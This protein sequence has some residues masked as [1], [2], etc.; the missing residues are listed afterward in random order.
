MSKLAQRGKQVQLLIWLRSVVK[1]E[2]KW[3]LII[4]AYYILED[5]GNLH[6]SWIYI[7]YYDDMQGS[8]TNFKAN[9]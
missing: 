5:M 9:Q 7:D 3:K 6:I 4:S 8:T 2:D 1:T